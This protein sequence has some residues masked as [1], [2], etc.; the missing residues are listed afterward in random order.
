MADLVYIDF[1]IPKIK[2]NICYK[3]D[4]ILDAIKKESLDRTLPKV[5]EVYG[6]LLFPKA[7]DNRPYI[8]CSVVLSADGKMAYTDNQAGPVI[9]RNN[10][11]DPD[12]ALADYWV[13]NVLRSYADGVIIGARTLQKEPDASS[14][15]YDKELVEQ[16]VGVLGKSKF[17]WSIIASFDATDIPF[18]HLAFDNA[19]EEYKVVIATSPD[20]LECIK[21]EF[22]KPY[23]IIGPFS[24]VG[25]I[26]IESVRA[27]LENNLDKIPVIIT[28]KGSSPDSAVLLWLLRKLGLERLLI[29]SPSYNWHLM[30]NNSLDEFFINYSMVYAGGSITPGTAMPFSH[31]THP[32]AELLTLGTHQSNFIFTRQKIYYGVSKTVDL[33]K[34]KY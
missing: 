13:L 17:P 33:G 28:G 22:N 27:D 2:L 11:L 12:G 10:Y 25:E 5:M 16:R 9:S 19:S 30:A 24:E 15:V 29:E 1:P 20:G 6:E 14:H 31:E 32:H 4:D 34:Y 23:I 18:D 26:N 8:F 3:R 21:R 7:L